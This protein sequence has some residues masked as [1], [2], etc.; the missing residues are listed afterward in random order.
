[1]EKHTV[2][3]HTVEKHSVEKHTVEKH[4]V[5]SDRQRLI[6][7]QLPEPPPAGWSPSA[8]R[9]TEPRVD[10]RSVWVGIVAK[11]D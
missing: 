6:G 9:N 7:V 4:T 3:K 1:M 10:G 11:G 5:E 2:E 8:R